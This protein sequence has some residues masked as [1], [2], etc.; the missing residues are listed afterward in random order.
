MFRTLFCHYSPPL[1]LASCCLCAPYTVDAM[2]SILSDRNHG[3]RK[4]EQASDRVHLSAAVHWPVA[5]SD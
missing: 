4:Y 2:S 5:F 1:A 3:R